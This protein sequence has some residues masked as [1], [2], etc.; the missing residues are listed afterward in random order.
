MKKNIPLVI[1]S[2]FLFIS[3]K[4]EINIVNDGESRHAIII[5]QNA[6]KSD[7][8]AALYLAKYILDMT[9]ADIPVFHDSSPST[10]FEI[11]LGSTNRHEFDE[12]FQPDGYRVMTEGNKLFIAGGDQKGII[13]GVIDLLERWGCRRF[14]PDEMYIPSMDKLSLEAI[15][16]YNLPAN[17]LRIING[18]MTKDPEF[19]DWLRISTIQETFP[20]GYYVHTFEKLIPRDE[21]FADHPEYY[22]WLGNKYSFDQLCPSNPEVKD[23]TIEKLAREMDKHPDCDNWAVSQSDNFT[24]CHCDKC[25]AIIQEEGSPAG[26]VIRLVNDVA[27]AFPEKTITTLA[28]QFSRPA[29]Q[30]TKPDSNVMVMLCTIELN[31]SKPINDDTASQSFVKDIQDWG[32]ICNNIYLWDYTINFN[33]SVSPFPN[34]HVLQPNMQF[35]YENGVRMQFPQSNLQPGHEFVELKAK[36]LSALMWDPYVNID[37]VKDDF[38]KNYY[39]QAAPFMKDYAERMENELISSGKILYIY[40]PP[41]NHSEGYLSSENILVYNKLFDQAEAV[42]AGRPK[43]LNRVKVSRLPLQ[44]AMMEIGKN[45]MFGLRGWYDDVDGKFVLREEMKETLEDFYRV[46]TSN[47]ITTLN[48]R[49]LTPDIYYQSTLRFI[50]VKV[51]GNMAFRKPVSV[52]PP[53][54]E[55]YAKGDPAILTNGVQ[56]AHDFNVHWLGWWGQDAVITVDLKKEMKPKKIEIGTLWDGKSWIL[57]PV[58]VSCLVSTDG[59]AYRSL[60]TQ[61]V[62][63]DQQFEKVTRRF[64]FHPDTDHIRYIKFEIGGA[65]PLPGWH[66]SE[67]EPSW[68]FVDEIS[69]H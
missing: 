27:E 55:K 46:C 11:C 56:G 22:A 13:Y 24:Y 36:M 9:G 62:K 39:Q 48:E 6:C 57:H 50:D 15:N 34:L 42:V 35:F 29:P 44:Y 31:R 40:N 60:G 59:A 38:Y 65:G 52:A 5:S 69:V 68:L 43:I 33:H 63:G 7:S 28:Y 67:G 30:Q 19:A 17:S 21:Y 66:A 1:I 41:N 12:S 18:Q 26:P 32:R 37:S 2:V 25:E 3:C 53:A 47:S 23:L 20:P 8:T 58:S 4:K 51:E 64:T 16:I 14:S 10:E 61:Q 45:D 54:A 49:S